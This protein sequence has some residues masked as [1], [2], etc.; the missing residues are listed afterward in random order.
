MRVCQAISL[1]SWRRKYAM[2]SCSH[3]LA[4]IDV[5]MQHARLPGDLVGV[6]AQEIRHVELFPQAFVRVLVERV[7]LENAQR[8][9]LTRFQ[10]GF[11][12]DWAA[13]QDAARALEQVF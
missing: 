2:S 4:R 13:A 1:A 6:V 3:M 9:G 8:L 5:V 10:I 7:E 11:A 12:R